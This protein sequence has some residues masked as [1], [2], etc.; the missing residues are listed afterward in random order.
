MATKKTASKATKSRPA[1]KGKPLGA[2]AR[3]IKGAGGGVPTSPIE[4]IK[5]YDPSSST[6]FATEKSGGYCGNPPYDGKLG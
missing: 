5:G 6:P 4:T 3:S 1:I 2:A